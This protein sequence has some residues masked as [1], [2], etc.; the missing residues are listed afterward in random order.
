MKKIIH[1]EKWFI[2]RIGKRIYRDKSTC[3]CDTCRD[4]EI[5]GLIVHDKEHAQYL[6]MCQND[7]FLNYY[8]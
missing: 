4:V 5:N 2:D 3:N 6:H 1:R 8:D 7:L